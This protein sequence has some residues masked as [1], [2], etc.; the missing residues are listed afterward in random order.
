MYLKN[1]KNEFYVYIYLNPLKPGKY[2]YDN[3]SFDFDIVP[4]LCPAGFKNCAPCIY[5]NTV[6]VH[7]CPASGIG[8]PDF[9]EVECKYIEIFPKRLKEAN[10]ARN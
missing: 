9:G 6:N 10:D 2:V 7:N 8:K 3:I 4:V 5:A 1:T